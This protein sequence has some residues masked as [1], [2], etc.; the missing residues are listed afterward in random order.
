MVCEEAWDENMGGRA[1]RFPPGDS[2]RR[3]EATQ[4]G[5][6]LA[7]LWGPA[8]LLT[9]STELL[10]APV[11]LR[12]VRVKQ[13]LL[14]TVLANGISHPLLWTI[15]PRTWAGL[16]AGECFVLFFEAAVYRALAAATFREALRVSLAAN[17]MSFTLGILLLW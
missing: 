12:S 11:L 8:F 2:E 10:V 7:N 15:F 5:M 6:T 9:L 4:V 13:A 16:A 17:L 1:G 3:L 14:A